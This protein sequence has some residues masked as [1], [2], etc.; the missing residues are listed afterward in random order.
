M[1]AP[2]R[3]AYEADPDIKGVDDFLG[4]KCGGKL[5]ELEVI[6]VELDEAAIRRA[7]EDKSYLLKSGSKAPYSNR[8]DSNAYTLLNMALHSGADGTFLASY[9]TL[10]RV[11]SG[12]GTGQFKRSRQSIPRA[13]FD[14]ARMGLIAVEKGETTVP[15]KDI[16]EED[17][18]VRRKWRSSG[19]E[20]SGLPD[21]WPVFRIKEKFRGEQRPFPLADL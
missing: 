1:A 5:E 18:K 3:E 9:E 21:T 11:V 17:F 19:Y 6:E 15:A 4:S 16:T 2:P 10:S 7:V 20:W 8:V 13:M 14:L 12:W